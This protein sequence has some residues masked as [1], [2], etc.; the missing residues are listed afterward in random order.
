MSDIK[1]FDLLM[2]IPNYLSKDKCNQ[3]I[4][5]YNKNQQYQAYES[6]LDPNGE[7]KQSTFKCIEVIPQCE[8]VILLRNSVAD[9]V[10]KYKTYLQ[11]FNSFHDYI[12]ANDCFNY[13]H[14]YRILKYDVGTS[15]HQHSDHDILT[16]GSCTINLNDDYE[17]GAFTF[18]K[19][20]NKIDL[21]QGDAIVFP[22]DYFWVHEVATI[23]KGTRYAFNCFLL[24]LLDDHSR[25]FSKISSSML[26]YENEVHY[27]GVKETYQVEECHTDS[28]EEIPFNYQ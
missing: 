8:E 4:N 5:Y 14:K 17:G 10:S 15:I 24:K 23:T 21:K 26:R 12:Q 22:A 6:S 28:N 19:G 2:Y 9:L 16:Y 13:V 25:S 20:R 18:F 7:H 27:I 3:L 11:S 1:L